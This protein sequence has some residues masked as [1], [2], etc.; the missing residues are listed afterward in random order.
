[1]TAVYQCY[2]DSYIF[3]FKEY[4]WSRWSIQEKWVISY[5]ELPSCM[6]HV[7]LRWGIDHTILFLTA[8]SC[9]FIIL[10][11][12]WRSVHLGVSYSPLQP[13]FL[14]VRWRDITKQRQRTLPVSPTG[15]I[16]S[17]VRS[18]RWLEF[19]AFMLIGKFEKFPVC[20]EAVA[21][22]SKPIDNKLDS[23]VHPSIKKRKRTS[24]KPN[25]SIFV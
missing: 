18:W 23:L 8:S 3:I 19:P 10:S 9:L 5:H 4:S 6:N 16:F 12:R 13:F 25:N 15:R 20:L 11:D 2:C 7:S 24:R 22:R 1:M 14:D 21:A 17:L